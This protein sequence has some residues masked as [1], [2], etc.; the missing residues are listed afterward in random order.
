M[1]MKYLLLMWGIL[2][3]TINSSC[4]NQN[5]NITEE[6]SVDSV[7]PTLEDKQLFLSYKKMF[8][9]QMY[10]SSSC[11]IKTGAI[12]ACPNDTDRSCRQILEYKVDNIFM[13]ETKDS[14]A[15]LVAYRHAWI[16]D[17]GSLEEE[18]TE[19]LLMKAIV[20]KNNQ[21]EFIC[22]PNN[23]GIYADGNQ[24]EPLLKN[25]KN[26]MINGGGYYI[27]GGVNQRFIYQL[28][29]EPGSVLGNI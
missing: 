2:L 13:N 21:L 6:L 10:D 1:K 12:M 8:E 3:V 23:V 7:H 27:N 14:I 20:H 22:L 29:N 26:L 25:F 4:T 19:C 15:V 11:Y 5:N 9:K 17:N 24:I 28:F 16:K 18:I